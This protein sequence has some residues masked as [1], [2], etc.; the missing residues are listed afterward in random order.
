MNTD[1]TVMTQKAYIVGVHRHAFKAGEPGEIIGTQF[2][3]PMGNDPFGYP[4]PWRLA[5][6]VVYDDGAK[7]FV[8]FVDVQVYGNYEIIS[9]VQL[10]LGQIPSI[11]H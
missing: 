4:Y 3:R 5:Y 7:D 1:K 8:P 6:V 11:I 10:A 2:V 9:D